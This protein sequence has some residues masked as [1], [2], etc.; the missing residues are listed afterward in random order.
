MTVVHFHP[1]WSSGTAGVRGVRPLDARRYYWELQVSQRVFGTS[2]MFGVATRDARLHADTFT[3]LLGEDSNG[4][5]LSHKGLLWHDGR[6]SYYTQPFR[7]NQA[8][9][10]GLLYD[11]VAGTLTYY[12]V[13]LRTRH[14]RLP[15][16]SVLNDF[17]V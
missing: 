6:W 12:K 11:G 1:N 3:N 17:L 4:W 7:E 5:G 16:N 8:T 10:V 2:I 13:I 14:R 9:T 15:N